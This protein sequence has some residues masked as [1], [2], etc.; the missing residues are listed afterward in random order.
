MVVG[1][2][3]LTRPLYQRQ[4]KVNREG[5]RGGGWCHGYTSPLLLHFLYKVSPKNVIFKHYLLILSCQFVENLSLFICFVI[6]IRLS[7]A[8]L[9]QKI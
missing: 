8:L 2:Q 7:D 9:M 6:Y 5:H 4:S 1:G 3:C